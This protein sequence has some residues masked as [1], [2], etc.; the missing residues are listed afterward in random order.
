MVQQSV[1]LNCQAEGNPRPSYTW[2]PCDPGQVC[3]KSILV[4]S[5][6]LN[7]GVYACKVTNEFGSDAKY[8]I[9]CKLVNVLT[10]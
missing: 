7:D 8:T 6:V 2:T 1:T 9:V 10:A 3:D 5:K 4:I